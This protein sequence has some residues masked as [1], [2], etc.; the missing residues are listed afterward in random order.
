MEI[1]AR[2]WK[3]DCD[4]NVLMSSKLENGYEHV[5]NSSYS[6][7]KL[8][9]N[10]NKT[11]GTL[12]LKQGPHSLT[13]GGKYHFKFNFTKDDVL[14]LFAEASQNEPLAALIPKL[15]KMFP[16]QEKAALERCPTE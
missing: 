11:T 12:E 3:R 1:I 5:V 16:A 15:A 7:G 9:F 4:A 14:H 6:P 8:Y 2:G 10:R 13:L